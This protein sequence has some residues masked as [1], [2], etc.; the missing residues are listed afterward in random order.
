MSN[1]FE[2]LRRKFKSAMIKSLRGIVFLRRFG[3][4][5]CKDYIALDDSGLEELLKKNVGELKIYK[6]VEENDRPTQ[7]A[8]HLKG[9]ELEGMTSFVAQTEAII[10]D[11]ANPHFSFRNNHLLDGDLNVIGER[12][13]RFEK[14]PIRQKFLS[15]TKEL[16]GVVAYLSNTDPTNYYHWMCRT[17]PMIRIYK[18]L[19]CFHEIDF[20]YVGQ[21]SLQGFHEESLERAG[22]G[23]NQ[24][25]Q[26]A[27][28]AD[29]LISAISHRFRYFG[30]APIDQRSHSFTRDLFSS[31][32][33][34]IA[35]DQRR[36][37]YVQRG[38]V[39][40]RKVVNEEEVINLLRTYGFES[41]SMDGK[42]VHE[43]AKLF[44]QS[45]AIVAPHGAALTNLLF[46]QPGT[47]VIE[48]LPYGYVNNCYYALT[49]YSESEYY[50]LN[51]EN[52]QMNAKDLHNIDIY[53]DIEKLSK[54]CQKATLTSW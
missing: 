23:L 16:N 39:K 33:E 42:T 9:Q 37:I 45:E 13:V 47:K 44:W 15:K 51:S 32:L 19:P 1:Y 26:Y 30:S 50:Y 43:Q 54:L 12:Q 41:V 18:S 10:V 2:Q 49:N 48:I 34:P 52:I 53:V 24:V 17:L 7:P 11:I 40:R 38:E 29:R 6:I 4:L 3:I 46:V 28:T 14:F 36:R 27:C 5:I 21:F 31:E 20:F 22:I 8:I 25:I 35:S